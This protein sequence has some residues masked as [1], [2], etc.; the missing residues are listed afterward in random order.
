MG[1]DISNVCNANCI[2]CLAEGGRRQQ[3]D[4][5]A[6]REPE[7]LDNFEALLPFINMG[8]LSSYEALMNPNFEQFVDKMR[9]FYTPICLFTNGKALT[10]ETS[11]YLLRNGLNTLHCS[12]HA[13]QP[14]VY[15]SIMRGC[16]FDHVLGNLMQLKH[17][18]RKHNPNFTL[19]MVFCAMR[20]NIEQLLDY[21]DLAHRVGAR[22]IQVNYLMVTNPSHKLEKE[23]MF[24]CQDTYDSYVHTAK[25]KAAKLGIQLL[26]QPLFQT[27]QPEQDLG[28]CYRPWEH[29]NVNQNGDATVCCG[30]ASALG[31]VFEEDFFKVWNSKPLRVF[32]ETVNSGNPPAACKKCTRGRENPKEITTHITYLR[33]MDKD[34]REER[35]QELMAAYGA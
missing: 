29:V 31:N 25:M 10:P 21:V 32:R 2:F 34:A 9:Q 17:L 16:S 33:N 22:K 4:I 30:G 14:K 20:R 5:N 26:H 19:T 1:F 27:Y 7:W 28:P 3:K 15:E 8:I 24:F 35:I 12:F 18:A 13:A 11:E 6:F 23:S